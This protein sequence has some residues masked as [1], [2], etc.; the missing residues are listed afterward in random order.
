[1]NRIR[2]SKN[3]F[4]VLITPNLGIAPSMELMTGHWD[5]DDLC[6]FY[7]EEYSCLDDAQCV[8]FR[9]P[10]ID[11]YKLVRLHA[12]HYHQL[13]NFI[14]SVIFDYK[15][16]VELKA[17]YMSPEIL[18]ETT[19]NRVSNLGDRYSMTYDMNDIISFNIVNPWTKNVEK[20]AKILQE[21][22]ELRIKD[23]KVYG[24]KVIHLTGLTELGT[25]YEIRLWPTILYQWAEWHNTHS[26]RNTNVSNEKLNAIYKK[27]WDLQ[28][29]VD[30]SIHIR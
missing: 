20:L 28:D 8:A 24:N 27:Y 4:Q 18:K 12:D 25:T 9:L 22:P 7:I 19:F 15:F 6:G 11:W 21:M 23:V 16:M 13:N 14:K 17:N 29:N 2:Q 30:R 26:H 10:D 5:D 1:M 3:G